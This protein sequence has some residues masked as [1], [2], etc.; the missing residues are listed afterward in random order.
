LI[1]KNGSRTKKDCGLES[2]CSMEIQKKNSNKKNHF[3][4]EDI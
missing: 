4:K 2:I 3:K 1:T